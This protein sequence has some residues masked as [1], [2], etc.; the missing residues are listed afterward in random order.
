MVC[1]S[2]LPPSF[3]LCSTVLLRRSGGVTNR[4]IG[5]GLCH[6]HGSAGNST[7]ASPS[8]STAFL[9][10]R[11]IFLL[12]LRFRL[13][14]QHWKINQASIPINITPRAM[15]TE[16][17]VLVPVL[18]PPFG[19]ITLPCDGIIGLST[20]PFG[21]DVLDIERGLELCEDARHGRIGKKLTARR[22]NSFGTY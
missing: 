13:D 3:A 22:K 5:T 6:P 15:P 7:S 12:L 1:S 20:A 17:P 16:N 4:A 10:S 21:F 2:E 8:S 18:G 14:G 9:L 19:A 11:S